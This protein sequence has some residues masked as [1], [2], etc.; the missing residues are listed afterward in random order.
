MC[1][2]LLEFLVLAWVLQHFSSTFQF[3]VTFLEDCPR[4]PN[5][6]DPNDEGFCLSIRK[7]KGS[8]KRGYD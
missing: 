6:R 5:G 2:S 4:E 8:Q 7:R 3:L 1:D